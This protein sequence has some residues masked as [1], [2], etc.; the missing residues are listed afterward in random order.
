MSLQLCV[1][2]DDHCNRLYPLSLTRPVFDLRCGMSSLLEKIVRHYPGA[3]LHLFVRPYL[4]ERVRELWPQAM[5]NHAPGGPCLFVNGR[6]LFET[7]P[8]AEGRPAI[9]QHAGEM[10]ALWLPAG[11]PEPAAP[12]TSP[13]VLP[14]GPANAITH[15]I[16]GR[17]VNYPWDLVNNNAAELIRDFKEANLGGQLLGRICP[18]VTLL[19][20]GNIHLAAGATLKPGVVLDAEDGPI[21]IDA[22]ATIMANACL[23]GPLYVGKKSMIKMGAKIY[24][25]TAIGPVCKIGGEVEASIVHGFSNKQHEGF[26]G[27]AYLGE[28]VNL[29][30]DTNN[31]DLKN[32]YGTVKVY[33]DGEMVDSGS[34][35][36]GL[37]MGDHAKSGINTMFNTGT[38]V[39]VMSNV[40]GAGYP[41]KFIPSFIWGGVERSE[42]Y[43]L[44]KALAVAKRVMARRK[45]TLT[46]AQE[47]VL[48]TV[49]E[50]TARERAVFSGD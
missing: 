31:S 7:W 37:F 3:G 13:F 44:D 40:F 49:F 10:V 50:M 43:A 32:N 47:R 41:D 42:T 12:A 28:W 45:Q 15:E 17:F 8:V 18:G 25:G 16:A 6:F 20:A 4:A 38:V 36:V 24:E 34:L 46:P 27:H 23:Q 30:A 29:G 14:P 1:F 39:G 19:E 22:G 5:V 26:L 9:W 48:R 21:F 2:E 11:L 35:F 33:I